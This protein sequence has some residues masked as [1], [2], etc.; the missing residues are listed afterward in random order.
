MLEHDVNIYS[1]D[2]YIDFLEEVYL[3]IKSQKQEYSQREYARDL[4]IPAP[5]INQILNRKEGLSVKRALIV[6][7]MIDMS[8]REREYFSHL[9]ALKTSKSK[10]QREISSEYVSNLNHSQSHQYL[11]QESWSIL[12][13]EGWDIIW[14]YIE[15]ES[16]LDKLRMK[17]LD[18]GMKKELFNE[19]ILS[20][21]EHG[22]IGVFEGR[23]FKKKNNIAFGNSVSSQSIK[24]YHT[25]KLQDSIKAIKIF[26]ISNRKNESMSFS[27]RKEDFKQVENRIEEFLDTLRVDLSNDNHDEVYTINIAFHPAIV[28]GE[29]HV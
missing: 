13:L 20:F 14:N 1:Y 17:C 27:L 12:D 26:D 18:A 19:V 5:R 3:S 22:L 9:V 28:K 7:Q 24:N 16:R 8:E 6:S 21:I 15:I 4:E 23:A 29:G 11:G 10:R 2:D 25:R